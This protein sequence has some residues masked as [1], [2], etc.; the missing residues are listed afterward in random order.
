MTPDEYLSALAPWRFTPRQSR[1]VLTVALHSG[2]CLR[3][4]YM[5]FAGI[6]Y[7]KVVREFLETLV[8]RRL[9]ER[10]AYRMDR[11]F[12]YHVHAR[13][14]YRAIGQD[15]NRNRR[16]TSPAAIARKLMLLDYV[17]AEPSAEWYATEADKVNLFTTRFGVPVADLPQRSYAAYDERSASS[18]RYFMHKLP[19][20]V[21]GEPPTVRL[22]ALALDPTGQSFEQ[23]LRDHARLLSHLSAWTI[24]LI[25][26]RGQVS[27]APCRQLFER[28][29]GRLSASTP[30]QQDVR[31]YFT[32]RRSVERSEW[33]QLSAADLQQLRESRGRFSDPTF[34]SLYARW[35]ATGDRA[36]TEGGLALGIGGSARGQLIEHTLPF[37]YDQFGD[38]PGVC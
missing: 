24:V 38:L 3:R 37:R 20:G 11:G 25:G 16:R 12:V 6:R 21:V 9:A 14:L 31:Q 33:A 17:I 18:T 28:Y 19:V 2:Y 10:L 34:D 35:L 22:V 13:A 5:A 4:Q 1:F 32:L 30:D 29:V 36:F 8:T 7:G 23:F 27:V 15:D 26:P